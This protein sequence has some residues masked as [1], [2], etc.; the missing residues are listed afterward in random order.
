MN[1]DAW[2][3]SLQLPLGAAIAVSIGGAWGLL[4]ITRWGARYSDAALFRE[5]EKRDRT[6]RQ[7]V[8]EYETHIKINTM[9]TTEHNSNPSSCESKP[10][11]GCQGACAVNKVPVGFQA[12][13]VIE[14]V[15]AIQV[16]LCR[17]IELSERLREEN[18]A[19]RKLL[20]NAGKKPGA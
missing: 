1:F 9:N 11:G 8:T 19:L 7:L 10:C 12:A 5:K 13:P 16:E 3:A 14:A 4:L 15:R 20:E 18:A 2:R 6:V 17:A